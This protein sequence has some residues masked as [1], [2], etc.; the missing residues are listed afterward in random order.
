MKLLSLLKFYS[1]LITSVFL[2]SCGGSSSS[3]ATAPVPPNTKPI[4]IISPAGN[5]T[6]NVGDIINFKGDSS[7][8]A[9]GNTPLTYQWIFSG[10][11]TSIQSSTSEN[12]G[13]ITFSETGTV[14]ISL[15]VTD[16]LGLASN[17]TSLN[18]E[19]SSVNNNQAPV[20]SIS[21]DNGDGSTGTTTDITIT[22]GTNIVF[23][24]AITDPENDVISY[25]WNFE[26][27]TPAASSSAGN[28]SVNY[29][30][31]GSY[32]V[33]LVATDVNGNSSTFPS[34]PLNVTVTATAPIL[35]A[36]KSLP[37]LTPNIVN[38]VAKYTLD[39]E[40]N[41]NVTIDTPNGSWTTPMMRYNSL[42]LQPV[43]AAKRGD[44]IEVTVN[45]RLTSNEE[46]TVH[47]HGFKI[48]GIEDGGPDFPIAA[49][50]SRTY[51]FTMNQAAAPIWFHPHAH[52]TTAT[53]VYKGLAGAFILTDSITETL[54]NNNQLPTGIHDVALLVQDRQFS[55]DPNNTGIRNLIYS[56]TGASGMLGDTILVNGV[57]MPALEVNTSQYRFRI[58][59]GSNARTYDFA[60]DNNDTFY[61]VSTDG[62]LLNKPVAVNHIILAAG[63][64][65]EIVVDFSNAYRQN[66]KLISKAFSAGGG[67][68]GGGGAT[69]ANGDPFDVMRFDV[70]TQTP[71]P[72]TLYTSLP[73]NAD[74]NSRLTAAM[75]DTTRTFVMSMS[76]MGGG[77]MQFL[78]NNKV[79]DINRIDETVPSGA[80]EIWE[81]SNTSQ[82]AHPFHA[83]AIQWQILDRGTSG[84]TLTPA[85]GI[86]LGWK[87]T[88]LVQPN[89]TVRFIG[90]FD[91]VINS[92]KYMYHC[93]ILEHEDNGMMGTFEVLP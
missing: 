88:V 76:G 87:D 46:T 6:I 59:N 11:A 35:P 28:I 85:S 30:N 39:V 61:V 32:T 53:Q 47:W 92:G 19:V 38:G 45:N 33:T 73:A 22:E 40:E 24:S 69:L 64:R 41:V 90:K 82:I 18:V 66:I 25:A 14:T 56:N 31:K 78:I 52:G 51:S 1:I 79:F 23:D 49:N 10:A 93:H 4:A 54:E 44:K 42:P 21:H 50:T 37:L 67:M 7:S 29:A 34:S 8:D 65:A 58:F 72:V 71:D 16:S 55:D 20:G 36:F 70:T 62:G 57:E 3:E 74:I 89:E 83:H 43:I 48:P 63:E 13:D 5:Q 26:G 68:G 91:P 2:I 27:A 81:I 86:D 84:S 80:T 12:P 60:L 15:V 75:S 77:G 17:Q 9:D